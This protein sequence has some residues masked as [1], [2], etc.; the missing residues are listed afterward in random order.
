MKQYFLL[1]DKQNKNSSS[2]YQLIYMSKVEGVDKDHPRML[3]SHQSIVE[4]ILI[5]A[6][7]SKIFIGNQYFPVKK[8][9]LIIYNSG[10]VHD[11]LSSNDPIALYCIGIKGINETNLR[12]DALIS[13]R[14]EPIFE[15]GQYY[16]VLLPL[17]QSAFD[18]LEQEIN[19]YNSL[20]QTLGQ[21]IIELI[22]ANVINNQ[23]K[24]AE[25][26]SKLIIVQEIKQYLDVHFSEEFKLSTLN[27]EGRWP[28]NE[29]YFA[30][31]FKALY[32]YTPIEYLQ[33]RRIGEAQTLLINTDLSITEIAYQVGF[34]SSSY[35]TTLFKKIVKLTP[36]TYR[37]QYTAR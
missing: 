5:T 17:F 10:V 28:I 2:D 11:E 15:T 12:A 20:V 30:H 24:L 35:F 6:G 7:S 31:K 19:N 23:S 27:Q 4:L 26:S 21:T 1:S 34:N 8:G 16:A 3:H 36:K 22:K 14:A 29:Y 37:N 32:D 25:D 33:R 18:M 9:D 13:D